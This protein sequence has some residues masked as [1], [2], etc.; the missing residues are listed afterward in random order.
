MI[1]RKWNPEIPASAENHKTLLE[2]YMIKYELSNTQRKYFGLVPVSKSWDREI[3]NENIFIYFNQN[4]IVKILDYSYGYL[5]YDTNIHTVQRSFISGR[6][7]KGRNQKLTIPKLLKIKGCGTQFSISFKGGGIT[8]YDNKRNIF[9][10]KS[11]FEDGQIKDIEEAKNWINKFIQNALPNYF[12]W[13]EKQLAER[14]KI[15]HAKSGDII[16]FNI[17]QNEYGFAR[18]LKGLKGLDVSNTMSDIFIHPRSLTVATYAFTSENL[19]IDID[20]L[21][22]KKTLP[23]IY[24]LDNEI[25]YSQFPIIAHR[26]LCQ[27]E[28]DIPLPIENSTAATIFYTKTDI[29]NFIKDNNFS[30]SL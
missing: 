23:S 10:I 18:I 20:K 14:R 22:S 5:E 25:Y 4:E 1:P 26:P 12:K 17:G 7:V 24:V 11:Y 2:A 28:L 29:H 9:F 16:A 3:F 19:F 8:V 30:N 15:Q 27:K 13:L 21:I 6:T